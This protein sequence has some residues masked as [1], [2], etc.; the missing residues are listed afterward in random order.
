VISCTLAQIQIGLQH[1]LMKAIQFRIIVP[2][3]VVG[4]ARGLELAVSRF[5]PA[6]LWSGVSCGLVDVPEPTLPGD[7]WVKIKTRYGGICGSDLGGIHL[8]SS[9]YYSVFTSFPFTFGHENV[10]RIAEVGSRVRDWQVGERVVVEPTLWCEP[11][12]FEELCRHCARG[13]INLCEHLTE[14]N[15]A[16]GIMIG[17]C[18]DTGGSWGANFAAH[19]SQLYRVPDNVGDE[20]ALLVEPF[21]VALHAVLQNFPGDDE[22]V[23]V[24]GAG[25]IGLLTIAALRV[26]GS[27]ARILVLARYPFQAEAARRLG[28]TETIPTGRGR[29]YYAEIAQRTGA[30]LRKPIMGKRVM[31]GGVDRTFECVGSDLALDDAVRTTRSGG[32]V[33][34]V[35]VPGIPKTVDWTA[36]FVKEL[37][38]RGSYVYNHAEPFR[39]RKWKAF[40]LTLDLMQ[41][42]EL[43]VGWL[44]TH[45]FRLRD[46]ARA[47][48]F[49]DQRG[50]SKAIRAVFEFD[51]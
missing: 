28:A 47:F 19:Q 35:G 2:R 27:H 51:E 45:K 12:G 39:G 8:E 21:G 3:P 6:I 44:V 17:Y 30:R 23:L 13:E 32:R 34:L 43:D 26:L 49:L 9:P 7:D 10:G 22:T 25:A 24:I 46:Y 41:R 37:E 11:R 38:V 20:N 4:L 33:V 42:G 29:D 31:L 14:G 40:E 5:Y 48:R 50:A 36:I 18:H 15:L 16:P 1:F